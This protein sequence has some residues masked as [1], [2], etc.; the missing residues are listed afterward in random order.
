[1]RKS[2]PEAVEPSY[3]DI[4]LNVLYQSSRVGKTIQVYPVEVKGDVVKVKRTLDAVDS[5]T[6]SRAK[7]DRY[8]LPV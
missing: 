4:Q 2:K 5:S 7:F 3:K 8:Y 6:M 1:M